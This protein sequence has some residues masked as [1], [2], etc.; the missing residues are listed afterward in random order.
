MSEQTNEAGRMPWQEM[1]QLKEKAKELQNTEYE[2]YSRGFMAEVDP[3]NGG[4][5]YSPPTSAFSQPKLSRVCLFN[6]YDLVNLK[7]RQCNNSK[8]NTYT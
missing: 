1:R 5:R 4:R 7:Q 2:P 3:N 8:D 6:A